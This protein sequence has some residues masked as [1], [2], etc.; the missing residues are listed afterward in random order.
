MFCIARAA[1]PHWLLPHKTSCRSPK[2]A[3]L[4]TRSK[5]SFGPWTSELL[6]STWE[7][8]WKFRHVCFLAIVGHKMIDIVRFLTRSEW[9]RKHLFSRGTLLCVMLWSCVSD[10]VVIS[11]SI[12]STQTTIFQH[13]LP[14]N[15]GQ[16][17][18]Q[19]ARW[20]NQVSVYIVCVQTRAV[21]TT[22]KT[23]I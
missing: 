20:A 9:C 23:Q 17:G 19:V 11:I 15:A 18:Y 14:E 1:C 13:Q 8:F 5:C 10:W 2:L 4:R 6:P 21:K 3:S 16:C 22:F 7:Y 12:F